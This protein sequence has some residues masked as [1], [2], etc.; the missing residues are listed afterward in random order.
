[1]AEPDSTKKRLPASGPNL[2]TGSARS[3]KQAILKP[4][5]RSLGWLLLVPICSSVAT[6]AGADGPYFGLSAFQ[7]SKPLWHNG[8]NVRRDGH[9]GR[10]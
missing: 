8:L 2:I 10:I 6:E 7:P 5:L 1:M 9:I 4:R 3:T